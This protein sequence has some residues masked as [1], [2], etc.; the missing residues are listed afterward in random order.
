MVKKLYLGAGDL[1]D[2]VRRASVVRTIR[3]RL[4][5]KS[6]WQKVVF[7]RPRHIAA[8]HEKS[9]LTFIF[10]L[11]KR[12]R[13]FEDQASTFSLAVSWAAE[14]GLQKFKLPAQ[15]SKL[16][17]PVTTQSSDFHVV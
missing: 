17:D 11:G 4:T 8:S 3:L 14:A 2:A 5:N 9:E 16:A 13:T 6:N 15:Y 7:T 1:L 10:E 12:Q